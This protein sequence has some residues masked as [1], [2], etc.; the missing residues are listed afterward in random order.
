MYEEFPDDQAEK[1]AGKLRSLAHTVYPGGNGRLPVIFV[2]F[3]SPQATK[4][5]SWGRPRTGMVDGVDW[6]T[7]VLINTRQTAP[8]RVTVLHES[9]HAA[10]LD[11][12]QGGVVNF[13]AKGIDRTVMYEDQVKKRASAYFFG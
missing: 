10:N 8:D 3:E 2:P 6:L 13:M 4:G 5:I 1:D 11:H 9:G 7:F 12:N